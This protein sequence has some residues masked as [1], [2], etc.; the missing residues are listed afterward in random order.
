MPGHVSIGKSAAAG[1]AVHPRLPD[2]RMLVHVIS[3]ARI[4]RSV[5]ANQA[6][7]GVGPDSKSWFRIDLS[8]LDLA[9]SELRTLVF[10]AAETDEYLEPD[11]GAKPVTGNRLTV[12]NM[13]ARRL[14]KPWVNGGTYMD[15]GAGLI[16]AEIIDLFYRDLLGRVAD[17]EGLSGYLEQLRAG[18]QTL[19]DIRGNILNSQEYTARRKDAARAPGA[20]FSDTFVRLAAEGRLK[21]GV[22]PTAVIAMPE[23]ASTQHLESLPVSEIESPADSPVFGAGWHAAELIGG[24]PL[25]WMGRSALIQNPRPDLPV[26]EV[27]VHVAAVYGSRAPMVECYLDDVP[28]P[29]RV[30]RSGRR[31]FV[32]EISPSGAHSGRFA[33]LKINSRAAGSPVQDGVGRDDRVLSLNVLRMVSRYHTPDGT[34]PAGPSGVS[35]PV[36]SY[37]SE[38]SGAAGGP[39]LRRALR[40]LQSLT[41]LAK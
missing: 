19:E 38:R 4:L 3:G 8:S 36:A 28:A 39:R 23:T 2:Y 15:V 7:L 35:R 40:V 11:P 9:W 32:I 24:K 31:G 18:A 10:Y 37:T 14:A 26:R 20:I 5:I 41:G 17:P 29:A 12:E 27:S 25:R 22:V 30:V 6:P 1:W 13:L 21:A 34:A 16:E 33:S